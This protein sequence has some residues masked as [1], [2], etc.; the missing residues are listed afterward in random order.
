MT[1]ERADRIRSEVRTHYAGVASKGAGGGCCPQGPCGQD[2]QRMSARLGYT[3]EEQ[4]AVPDGSD[5]GLGCGT[6]VRGAALAPGEV[7]VDL[8]SG[9]GFDCFLAAKAVGQEGRVIGIDMTPEMIEK[10]RANSRAHGYTNVEFRIGEIEHLPLADRSANWVI[11]NCVVNLSPD[12]PQVYRECFRVLKPGGRL[13]IADVVATRPIPESLRSR[14]ELLVA[15]TV[16]ASSPADI[17]RWLVEAGFED[18]RIEVNDRSREFIR[19][20]VPGSGLEEHLAAAVI[21]AERPAVRG[22]GDSVLS[23]GNAAPP[24]G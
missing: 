5:L 16:G 8:G 3:G 20:W 19:D 1:D 15:C 14:M 21:Q 6:P 18:V 24:P 9:A 12:K 7:V 17:E 23:H 4:A 22:H 2:A 10:A 11:S 13:S